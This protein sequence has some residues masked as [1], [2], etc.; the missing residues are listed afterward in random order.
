MATG[1]NDA[2]RPKLMKGCRE[3]FNLVGIAEVQLL[4]SAGGSTPTSMAAS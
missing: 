3:I 2:L 1:D 4:S